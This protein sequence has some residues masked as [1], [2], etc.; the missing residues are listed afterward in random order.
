MEQADKQL[1]ERDAD[2]EGY[3]EQAD[4][5]WIEIDADREG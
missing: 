5:Q 1:T 3:M 4:K 2:R